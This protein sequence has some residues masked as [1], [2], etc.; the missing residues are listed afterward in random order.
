M[1]ALRTPV[2]LIKVGKST[3]VIDDTL[4]VGATTEAFTTSLPKPIS[5]MPTIREPLSSVSV[6]AAL[7]N[8]IAVPLAPAVLMIAPA[9]MM[10]LPTPPTPLA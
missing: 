4:V 6:S 10:V 2:K 8:L 5:T 3:V 9:L 7:D 1:L